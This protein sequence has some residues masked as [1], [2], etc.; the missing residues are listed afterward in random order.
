MNIGCSRAQEAETVTCHAIPTVRSEDHWQTAGWRP[1]GVSARFVPATSA[2]RMSDALSFTKSP[3]LGRAVWRCA[4]TRG[5][6]RPGLWSDRFV[7]RAPFPPTAGF[8][9][10]ANDRKAN[11]GCGIEAGLST[12]AMGRDCPSHCLL[13]APN[14]ASPQ[15]RCEPKGTDTVACMNVGI[16]YS[17]PFGDT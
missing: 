16:G 6:I 7:R 13:T 11:R 15:G 9:L 2:L 17:R 5:A 14:T 1:H 12:A 3:A 10:A 8:A 4:G